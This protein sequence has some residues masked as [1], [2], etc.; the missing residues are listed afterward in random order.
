MSE[1]FKVFLKVFYVKLYVH[2]LADKL[3]AHTVLFKQTEDRGKHFGYT[4]W[5]LEVVHKINN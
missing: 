3:K 4:G 1:R 2:L 5:S